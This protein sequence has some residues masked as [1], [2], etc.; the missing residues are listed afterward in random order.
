MTKLSEERG[1]EVYTVM[2]TKMVVLLV[3]EAAGTPETLVTFYQITW[4]FSPEDSH[5][6]IKF[7]RKV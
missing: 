7:S 6:N 4:R 2:S 1:F 5:L 3:M